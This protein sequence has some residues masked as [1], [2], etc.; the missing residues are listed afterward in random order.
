MV[1]DFK[2]LGFKALNLYHFLL[3][4]HAKAVEAS[5]VIVP[6]TRKDVRSFSNKKLMIFPVEN[7]FA[8]ETLTVF[9]LVKFQ[10]RP[11]ARFF[12]G[13]RLTVEIANSKKKMQG[14]QLE[15]VLKVEISK[16]LN[17][18]WL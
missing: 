5:A 9:H 13:E 10:K 14:L 4:M 7:R 16:T 11:L 17:A 15:N 3:T 6:N 18:L 2:S 1:L 12:K 8:I